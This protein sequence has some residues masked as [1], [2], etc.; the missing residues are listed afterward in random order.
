MVVGSFLPPS[1]PLGLS[2]SGGREEESVGSNNVFLVALLK[3]PS[4]F[5]FRTPGDE[6][7]LLLLL[8]F[9][10]ITGQVGFCGS[11]CEPKQLAF[12]SFFLFVFLFLTLY[13]PGVPIALPL[14]LL[15]SLFSFSFVSSLPNLG[16]RP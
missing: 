14:S 9:I 1:P 10:A 16:L 8:E 15:P 7:T 2:G 4:A 12:S 3:M 6:L 5:S 11:I 13:C